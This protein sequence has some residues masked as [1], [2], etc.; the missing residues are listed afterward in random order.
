MQAVVGDAE[1]EEVRYSPQLRY[2]LVVLRGPSARQALES[3]RPSAQ[4]L[5]EAYS[6]DQLGGVIVTAQGEREEGGRGCVLT[7]SMI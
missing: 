3:L 2:L 6:G 5:E 1:V 7:Q 4:S